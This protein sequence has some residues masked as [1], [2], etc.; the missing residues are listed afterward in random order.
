MTVDW[1]EMFR[2]YA[3]I[4]GDAESVDF[5]D[6]EDWSEEE[7]QAINDAGILDYRKGK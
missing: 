1:K 7:W 4:V 3:D 2:K 5:L 6:A